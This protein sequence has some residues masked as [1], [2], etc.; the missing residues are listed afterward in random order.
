[1]FTVLYHCV[2]STLIEFHARLATKM[3]SPKPPNLWRSPAILATKRHRRY[4]ER[5][6]SRYPT[7]LNRSRLSKQTHLCNRQMSKANS[8]HYTKIIAGH[9][10]DH[11]SLCQAFNK[12]LHRCPKMY[13]P[14]HSSIAALANTFTFFFSINKISI[15]PSSFPS[16]SCSNVLTP[17][18]TREIL[19]NLTH[20]TDDEVC[21][22]V[23]SAPCKSSDFD[24]TPTS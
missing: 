20:V 16:G 7:A 18:K 5:V 6:W 15:I 22:L 17:P 24:P 2:L 9:S 10:G 14:D 23:L 11:R 4:L 3:I 13:L 19:H 21:R 12:I 8:A 1:M